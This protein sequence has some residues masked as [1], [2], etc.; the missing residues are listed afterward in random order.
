LYQNLQGAAVT[1]EGIV[2]HCQTR[3]SP[4]ISGIVGRPMIMEYWPEWT[5]FVMTRGINAPDDSQ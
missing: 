4:G 2:T 1:P 3:P 5:V